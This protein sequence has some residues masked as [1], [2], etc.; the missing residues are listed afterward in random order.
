LR[1]RDFT[2]TEAENKNSRRVAIIDEE[3]AKK[4]FPKGDALGQ[5]IRYSQAPADG[6]PNEMEIVGIVTA[7]R[8]E[9]LGNE[10]PRRLFVPLGQ[11]YNG[12]V[13]L[14]VRLTNPMAAQSSP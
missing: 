9:T 6:S 5:R 8:H 12:D 4:L 10:I 3:M 7:H 2:A 1:G 11:A 14:R 13:Y